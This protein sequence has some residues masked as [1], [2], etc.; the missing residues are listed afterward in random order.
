MPRKS[1]FTDQQIVSVLREVESGATPR[2]DACRR[3]G[4][5]ET[6]FF[7][8]KKRF[9]GMNPDE[10]K[11]LR[12]LESENGRLKKLLAERDLEV[13]IMKEIAANKWSPRSSAATPCDTPPSAVRRNVAGVRCCACRARWPATS[14]GARSA[15]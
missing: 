7:R 15:T 10:A 5:T 6:T 8:W 12:E 2:A 13:E 11:R 1:K 9:G 3:L 4:V 14:L